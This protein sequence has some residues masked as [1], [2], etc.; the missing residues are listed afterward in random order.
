MKDYRKMSKAGL[1]AWIGKLKSKHTKSTRAQEKKAASDLRDRE[2]RLRAILE[3]AVEGI[4]TINE[5]GVIE[6]F[7]AASERIFGCKAAEVI[8]RNVSFLMP[9]PHHESHDGYLENYRRTGHA[10]IIGIGREVSGRRKDGTIFP[11]DLSVSE[12][13]LARRRLF[14]G[15]I[16][17]ITGR[18]DAEKA[19]QHQVAII[20]SSDDAII[21]KTL[22]G[23]ITSWNHGAEKIFGYTRNEA[24]GKNISILVPPNRADEEPA[25][26]ERFRRG[27]A[28]DH[29]ETVRRRKN[30]RFI[31]ISVTISPI[32]EPDGKIV[33]A[34]KV[35]RKST[36]LNSSHLVIS[37]AVFCL[38]KGH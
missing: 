37:Y 17:D 15:F 4:I 30:G 14:T 5:R 13:R 1:L 9:S 3:T 29:Y 16:R 36:R 35:A 31:D 34:S 24:L 11:M 27:E 7:N 6:S 2:E 38:K 28:V 32:R 21:G 10:K 25:I 33:G 20:D 26:I 18:K 8:G 19:L 12:V 22:Q 23:V